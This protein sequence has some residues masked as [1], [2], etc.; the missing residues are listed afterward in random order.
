ME[1]KQM[2]NLSLQ[3]TQFDSKNFILAKFVL[4]SISSFN[5]FSIYLIYIV[6]LNHT[7]HPTKDH[8]EAWKI[9]L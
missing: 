7:S 3:S 1:Q 4:T 6:E 8:F 9:A 2:V 5:F